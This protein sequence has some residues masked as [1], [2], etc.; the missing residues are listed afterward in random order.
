MEGHMDAT[1]AV[2]EDVIRERG[3]HLS[4]QLLDARAAVR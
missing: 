3:L 1:F 4:P 2:L